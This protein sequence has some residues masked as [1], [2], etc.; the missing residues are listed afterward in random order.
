M[1]SEEESRPFKYLSR[2]IRVG[3]SDLKNRI[4][5]APAHVGL[6]TSGGEVGPEFIGYMEARA[7]GGV[8]M[9][10]MGVGL[11]KGKNQT[12]STY[13]RMDE[14]RYISSLYK[15]TERIH[16]HHC[17]ACAQLFHPGRFSKDEPVSASDVPGYSL[18]QKYFKPRTMSLEEIGD[19]I[20]CF[21]DAA[22]RAKRANFDMVE[23]HGATGYLILQF[24]SP[25]TNKRTDKYG[26]SF[27]NRIRFPLEIINRIKEMCGDDFP[28]GFRLVGDE[29]LPDGFK[30]E[31]A[32][33]F[34]KR[35]E[36]A[37]VS[38][39]SITAG[40]VETR[41]DGEGMWSIRSP[42]APS[43][44]FASEIKREVGIPIMA[45]GQINDPAMMEEIVREGKADLIALARPLFSDPDLPNKVFRGD[46]DG[47]RKCTHCCQCFWHLIKEWPVTCFH[48]PEMGKELE[49]R[50]SGQVLKKKKVLVIG[51]G[52]GGL[53]AARVGA[54]K[55]HDVTVWEREK[56]P[57]GQLLLASKLPGK[58]VFDR[59]TIR[60]LVRQCEKAGVRIEANKNASREEIKAFGPEA[61]IVA[62]GASPYIPDIP[63]TNR[64]NVW[65]FTDIITEEMKF[66]NKKIV[67]IG[68]GLIGTEI[69]LFLRMKKNKI[70]LVE[71]LPQLAV[72]MDP[73]NRAY[74]LNRIKESDIA[75]L[76][77]TKAIE[78]R[79]SE[80]VCVNKEQDTS[81]IECEDVVIAAGTVPN[82]NMAY[83]IRP[84][85]GECV[86]IGDCVKPRTALEA[87]HEG[88]YFGRM[89]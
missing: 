65:K 88:S 79:E 80:V 67:I 75:V 54:L 21:G 53:S 9:V 50:F 84:F 37:G 18:R 5:L 74:L 60:W 78:I 59:Y 69:A 40:T 27:E 86:S 38:Y 23:L 26:G 39:L 51:G 16:L 32:K 70:T 25:R 30:L 6:T 20:E 31:E 85:T 2:P 8:A 22:L 35:L 14:D 19:M 56:N 1:I 73:F 63:G 28:I 7:R 46:I 11:V 68:G 72:N 44:P 64:K 77:N 13:P 83:Q 58:E 17:V 42:L 71:I 12:G 49:Y 3:N 81:Q 52:P 55:G 43:I 24:Y 45:N 57:G 34:A 4:V 89:I 29:L 76:T 61:V 15:L 36:E 87:I 47:V 10:I 41:F 48:N 62:T 33:V 66:E 82:N